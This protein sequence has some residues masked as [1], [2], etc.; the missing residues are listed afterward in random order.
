MTAITFFLPGPPKG[1]GRPRATSRGGH[2][3]LYTDDQTVAYENR[4]ENA[5]VRELGG[6]PGFDGPCSIYLRAVFPIPKS[7]SKAAKAAMAAGEVEPGK[8]PDLDNILKAVL[9]GL[10]HV[11]FTDDALVTSIRAVK[12]YGE[13]PGVFVSLT[14]AKEA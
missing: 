1:K 4:I 11:A 10:N 14:S 7:A 2:V 12:V 9:D 8:K 3:R 6:R 5:A 13:L